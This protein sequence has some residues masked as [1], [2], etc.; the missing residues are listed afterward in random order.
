MPKLSIITVNLNNA[1][2]LHKT[3]ESVMSQSFTDYEY[4][5]IDGVSNDSSL[6]VIKEFS[7]KITY[8]VS[9]PDNGIY[10]AM[11]KGIIK[12]TG[13]YCLF[14]NSGD[15]LVR[16]EVL[17]QVF[18]SKITEDIFYGNI[19]TGHEENDDQNYI[20]T[21]NKNLTF[22][23]F[24]AG[25]SIRHQASLI[26]RSLFDKYGLYNERY[27]IISDWAFF[28]KTI[29]FEN[30]TV[31][32]ENINISKMESNGISSSFTETHLH[33]RET[34][35]KKVLPERIL[36]DYEEMKFLKGKISSLEKDLNRLEH[37]FGYIDK[38]L[39]VLKRRFLT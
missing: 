17:K 3:I 2:G 32:Y 5:I 29:V 33:E 30:V 19:V 18:E 37:R 8:W 24:Y 23:D 28:I 27:S 35:L 10:H 16:N 13:E 26:K 7:D 14:L 11:N 12:A 22:F 39:S 21:K 25:E 9:E 20:N 36:I 4:I 15:Y 31:R 1:S 34:E 6:E 38:V